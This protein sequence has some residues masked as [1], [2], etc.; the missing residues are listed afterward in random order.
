MLVMISTY[1]KNNNEKRKGDNNDTSVREHDENSII[2]QY[3]YSITIATDSKHKNRKRL[4]IK[5]QNAMTQ[6]SIGRMLQLLQLNRF[7]HDACPNTNS[8]GS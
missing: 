8:C 4:G 5:R 1:E 7:S 6:T 2:I 3:K